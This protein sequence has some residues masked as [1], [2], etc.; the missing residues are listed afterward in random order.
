[1]S[2][3][4]AIAIEGRFTAPTDLANFDG[5][6]GTGAAA[7]TMGAEGIGDGRT[8]FSLDGGDFVNVYSSA[9]AAAFD[10]AKGWLLKWVRITDA[11]VWADA[12][13]RLFV[14]LFV[15]ANNWVRLS[16]GTVANQIRF[17]Y[18]AGGTLEDVTDTSL[19]AS[20]DWF[21]MGITWDKAADQVKAYL[22]GAQV[23]ATQTGLGTWAGSLSEGTLGSFHDGTSF[24]KGLLAHGAVGAGSVLTVAEILEV[25]NSKASGM[26]AAIL[27]LNPIAYWMLDDDSGTAAESETNTYTETFTDLVE[28]VRPPAHFEYGITGAGPEDLVAGTGIGRLTLDNSARNSGGALGYY[29]P[30]HVSKRSGFDDGLPMRVKI[31]YGGTD[32]YKWRGYVSSIMPSAGLFGVRETRVG[33]VDWMD[34]AASQRISQ[35]P[36]QTS[37]RVDQALRSILADMPIQPRATSFS[38]GTETFTRVFDTDSDEKMSPMSLFQKLARNEYGYIYLRGDLVGGETLVFDSRNARLLSL[39]VQATLD[40]DANDFEVEYARSGVKNIVRAKI[41]PKKV[42]AAAT[43]VLYTAQQSIQIAAGASVTLILPYRDPGTGTPISATAVVTPLVA[44]THF[45]FGTADGGSDLNANI[46]QS[47]FVGGNSIRLT[48]TNTGGTGGYL[49][50]LAIKGKGIYAYDPQLFESVD[51]ES[52]DARGELVQNFEMEQH[53]SSVKGEAF[54]L[55]LKN[56]AFIPRTVPRRLRFLANRSDALMLAFLECEPGRSEEHTSELQSQSN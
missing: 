46:S 2:V 5:V 36:I 19:A 4:A 35:L 37:K 41:Y 30:G 28:D 29:S 21:L 22:N 53:D 38:E 16:K 56:L 44:G 24:H 47:S 1:M 8:A 9:L 34:F 23:G 17:R 25:Y 27:A 39:T 13:I 50:S 43:T 18:E 15:D 32:Y 54:A 26:R 3:S 52:I 55:Y 31:T 10:G 51:Q 33:L 7:P 42:D 49:S 45:N 40:N 12:S 48:L 14:S 20:T 6:L 11:A